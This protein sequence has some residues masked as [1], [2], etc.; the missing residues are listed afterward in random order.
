MRCARS[1]ISRGAWALFV[2]LAAACSRVEPVKQP[3]AFNHKAHIKADIDCSTCHEKAA[4]GP[5]A[6]LPLLRV[7]AKCHKEVQG[8]DPKLE[9]G[10]ME[11]VSKKQEIPWIQV[12][13]VAGHV[14]FSHRAH[15]GFAEMECDVCHGDMK[16]Q[17]QPVTVPNV[18]TSMSSCI[19]CHQKKGASTDCLACHQ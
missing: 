13:E 11:A 7:C 18:A 8:K 6:T 17:E 16:A 10:I 15:V 12:N 9:E 3:M 2:V 14:Y 1:A 5:A 19:E 4:D